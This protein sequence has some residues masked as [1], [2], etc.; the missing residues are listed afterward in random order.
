MTTTKKRKE[1]DK[2]E[3]HDRCLKLSLPGPHSTAEGRAG[4]NVGAWV[5]RAPSDH[6]SYT[7][8]FGAKLLGE[9]G[10]LDAVK[11]FDVQP[12]STIV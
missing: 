10:D 8:C 11:T 1:R 4:R 9:E 6:T 2:G 3:L 5:G 12:A 7:R